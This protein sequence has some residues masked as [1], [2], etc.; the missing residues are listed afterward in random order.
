MPLGALQDDYSNP[1]LLAAVNDASPLVRIA[2]CEAWSHRNGETAVGALSK[3]LIDDDDGD[4]RIAAARALGKIKSPQAVQLLGST[5]DDRDPAV[6]LVVMDS[7]RNLTG[8]EIGRDVNA[9]YKYL[10]TQS[11]TE[12]SSSVIQASATFPPSTAASR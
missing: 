6:Q 1:T 4:V 7:L 9:W 3:L 5:L 10:A 12:P 8:Q 2:A 11:G